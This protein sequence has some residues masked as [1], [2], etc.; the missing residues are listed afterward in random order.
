MAG[1]DGRLR[2]FERWVSFL[3]IKHCYASECLLLRFVLP[4]SVFIN[5]V[6]IVEG[7][8]YRDVGREM[9]THRHDEAGTGFSDVHTPLNLFFDIFFCPEGKRSAIGEIGRAHV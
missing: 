2:V 6:K 3:L 7:V 4:P 1:K 5:Q 9:V 8:I